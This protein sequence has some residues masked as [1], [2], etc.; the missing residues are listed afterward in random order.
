LL[1]SLQPANH[2]VS[3]LWPLAWS[4]TRPPFST[5]A[6]ALCD[7]TT[8]R[9]VRLGGSCTVSGDRSASHAAPRG[10]TRGRGTI[11]ATGSH[12][13]GGFTFSPPPGLMIR[14]GFRRGSQAAPRHDSSRQP[15]LLLLRA[16]EQCAED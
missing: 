14:G 12:S 13:P 11:C 15:N 8:L 3:G 7:R 16:G 6:Q 10:A 2:L 5:L 4:A 9:L 1:L